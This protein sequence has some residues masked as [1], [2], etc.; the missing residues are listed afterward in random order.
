MTLISINDSDIGDIP[1]F[2]ML[3]HLVDKEPVTA[4]YWK[5]PPHLYT[6]VIN[7]IDDLVSNGWVRG[8]SSS[9]S[10]PIV[11]VRKKD[12]TMRRCV[13]LD[14]SDPYKDE[15]TWYQTL[16]REILFW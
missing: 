1:D 2:K 12:C 5:I 6:E 7:Y 14:Q 16:C 8:S 3:I 4:A 9:Y 13:D 10:S 11:C 15:G